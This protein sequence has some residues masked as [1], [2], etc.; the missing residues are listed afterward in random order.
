[1]FRE[2]AAGSDGGAA[3]AGE[4]M[5][6]SGIS[7]RA[8]INSNPFFEDWTMPFGMPPFERIQPGTLAQLK[9]HRREVIDPQIAEHK[10]RIVKTTGDSILIEFPSVVEA[11]A[12]AAAVQRRMAE[13]NASIPED[14]RIVF[15]VGINLGDIIVED[16]AI[17]D[18]RVNVAARLEVVSEPGGICTSATIG[19]HISDRLGFGVR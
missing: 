2:A 1:V 3:S 15:R 10:G 17:H 6:V 5:R 4:N 8:G 9:E 11:V 14:Q 19:D 16:A 12:C 7:A 18:D 13:R